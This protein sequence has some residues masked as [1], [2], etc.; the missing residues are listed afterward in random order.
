MTAA[1]AIRK[2]VA[3]QAGFAIVEV[4]VAAVLLTAVALGV[5]AGLDGASTVSAQNR[6]RSVAAGLAE[7]DQERMRS[8][9]PAQLSNLR[10]TRTV[11]VG[12][13]GYTVVSRADWVRDAS[14]AVSCTNDSTRADYM[15]ITSTVTWPRMGAVQPIVQRSLYAAPP[16][17]LGAS[18]G[19]AAV[20][21]TDRA[22][23]PLPGITA[24]LSGA[25]NY[26]DSTGA[27]GCAVFGRI[28][29][30]NYQLALTAPGYVNVAGSSPATQPITVA[31]DQTR[32]F[33]VTLDR[34]A[35]VDVSFDTWVAG[36]WV[37][38]QTDAVTVTGSGLP[39]PGSRTF[40]TSNGAD[41]TTVVASNL[42]P[43]TGGYAVYAG[44]CSSADPRL[45]PT[46]LPDY[47]TSN[48]GQIA[49]APGSTRALT[50]HLPAIN[51]VVK[52]S[53]G[54]TLTNAR[55]TVTPSD[56]SCTSTYPTQL[57]NAT[58]ALPAP[59]FPFG[60][61]S[62]CAGDGDRRRSIVT[63]QNTSVQGTATTTITLPSARTSNCP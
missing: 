8:L 48:P 19:T 45:A 14:G 41:A 30:G 32:L 24:A 6:S 9:T 13:I 53:S 16:G 54:Q 1:G 62:V 37:P 52:N 21:V 5:L 7:Q 40:T 20:Q 56:S 15:S 22:G 11:T 50:V 49:T 25:A 17:S 18:S 43:L 58:G 33:S 60:T 59:G 51:L 42:F 31:A 2:T 39:A 61:Y 10:A 44:S 63:I 55:V 47:F 36:A 29:A 38:A 28:P 35:R 27:D 3:D 26:G 57:T 46:S 34:A 23:H 12:Q 4:M